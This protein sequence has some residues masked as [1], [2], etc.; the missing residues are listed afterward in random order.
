M[1]TQVLA[2]RTSPMTE[3]RAKVANF[4]GGR[5]PGCEGEFNSAG[6]DL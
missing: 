6:E 4:L 3:K 1:K 5:P 2:V